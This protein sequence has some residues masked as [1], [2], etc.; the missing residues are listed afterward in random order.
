MQQGA[1]T[2][3][4]PAGAAAV[5]PRRRAA[6]RARGRAAGAAGVAAGAAPAQ[7]SAAANAG[8]AAAA[9]DAATST[10]G[11]TTP[12][13]ARASAAAAAAFGQPEQPQASRTPPALD[14]TDGGVLRSEDKGKT[15]TLV[16]NC[17]S[18]PMYFSQLRVDPSNDKTIYVAGLPVAKSLDGGKTFATLDDA[19]GYGEPG[20]V[21][22]HAIW[23]DPKNPKHIMEGNDGG[24]NISWDQGKSWDFVNTM[25]TGARLRR[26]RRHAASL[27]RLH[28]PAGQR[29]L[30]RP[31]RGARTRRDHELALVRHRRRRRLLHR[32]RSRPTTTSSSP[33]RR[34]ARPTATTSRKADA[35]AASGRTP[36][37]GAAARRRRRRSRRRGDTGGGEAEAASGAA[38]EGQ[39]APPVQVG[40]QGGFG[41]G[42]APNVINAIPGE[43]YRFNWNTPVIMSPHNPKIVYLGGNRLFKS[44]NQGDTWVASART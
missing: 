13:P 16:S 5:T 14:P 27:L 26:H 34:T 19:G 20:H 25:A 11:A 15:W 22:Q 6:R 33:S 41:R 1:A 42:G 2:E 23:I 43:S 38:A 12:G 28:R 37:A 18:R 4:T 10:T 35:A 31:E 17:N 21:D 32:R 36:A 40:G 7:A 29:Q 44:Y 3:A 9:A 24:L 30:G 39:P 8:S